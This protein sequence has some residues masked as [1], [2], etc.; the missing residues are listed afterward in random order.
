MEI[1]TG[2]INFIPIGVEGYTSELKLEVKNVVKYFEPGDHV[3]VIDGRYAGETGIVIS[4][5]TND[6]DVVF[7]N[8]AL[9]QSHR[10]IKVRASNLK[11]KTEIEQNAANGNPAFLMER[12]KPPLY[13]AG[14]LIS[15]DNN[16]FVG[17]VL[18]VDSMGGVGSDLIR[19][20]NE[21]GTVCN[22]RGNQVS[23]KFDQRDLRIKQQ[24]VDAKRN[25]IYHNN[26]VKVISGMC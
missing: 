18:S 9:L 13:C 10:E 25:T 19:L 15:Y 8:I 20:I 11:I 16:K 17:V 14:D 2:F 5:E 21:E 22:I 23:K 3:R 4:S 24:A 1:D 12:A 7:S 26:V 6:K